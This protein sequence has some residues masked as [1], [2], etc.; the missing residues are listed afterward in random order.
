[1]NIKTDKYS[2]KQKTLAT[3]ISYVG[4][5]L[6]TGRKVSMVVKPAEPE[7]GI[8]FVRKDVPWYHDKHR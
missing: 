2:V 3:S 8:S 5:G 1:M 7:T 4:V 6:H